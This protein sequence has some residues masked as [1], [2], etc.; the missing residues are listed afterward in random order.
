[1]NRARLNILS[2]TTLFP[3]R[4]TPF[5]GLFV[6]NRLERMAKLC[7]L[8]VVAPVNVAR[9]PRLAWTVPRQETIAGIPVHHPRFA[10]LPGLFKHWD[11]S[12]LYRHA[13]RQ[14]R[15]AAALERCDLLDVHYAYP[16]GVAGQLLAQTLGKPFVLSLR[17]S[18]I[19][20]LSQFPRRRAL[21]RTA[22]ER[23]SRIIA[24]SQALKDAA[25]QLG[26]DPAKIHVIPN[27]VD[28]SVF[29]PRDRQEARR[30]L[31]WPA[32]RRALLFV[33]R[34]S[35][36]KGL[37]L[38]VDALA[39]VRERGLSL[40]GHIVG[41]G[42]L[43]PELERTIARH[44]LQNAA[45]LH[46]WVAPADLPRW[47]SAADVVCLPSFSEGCPNVVVEAMAC[48]TP[49]VATAVGGVPDLIHEQVNGLLIRE[50]SAA[51]VA[52]ALEQACARPWDPAAIHAAA[53]VQDWTAVAA[54]QMRIFHD[55]VGR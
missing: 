37:D 22:L 51:A 12:L 49:V 32:G 40:H 1:M 48:G 3:N 30:A 19:H 38:L 41:D 29:F 45:T 42:E 18:D 24:V 25:Q 52:D 17:G 43:R 8:E 27:G 46:G 4:A 28:T 44:Q 21:I 50:H 15:G 34:L 20:V 14:M 9:D 26:A 5:H 36:V 54:A 53:A 31:G 7:D 39:L 10:V 33:G 6:K 47:Y 23:A 13:L 55:V 35:R 11:G 2:F 16:D